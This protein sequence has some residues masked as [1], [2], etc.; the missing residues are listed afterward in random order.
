MRQLHFIHYGKRGDWKGWIVIRTCGCASNSKA[1]SDPR[2]LGHRETSEYA[3]G[4]AMASIGSNPMERESCEAACH[5]SPAVYP[6]LH[7][8]SRE[9]PLRQ[10][11]RSR[12]PPV[13]RDRI[14]VLR[15]RLPAGFAASVIRTLVQDAAITHTHPGAPAPANTHTGKEKEKGACGLSRHRGRENA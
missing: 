2:P 14:L 4:H 11:L 6:R 13:H 9:S 5:L 10:R 8:P 15:F 12:L 3:R 1:S 7:P